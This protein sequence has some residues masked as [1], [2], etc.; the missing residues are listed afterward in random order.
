M[1]L[2][3]TEQLAA[4]RE[5]TLRL[6]AVRERSAAELRTRLRTRGFDPEVIDQTLEKMAASGLQSDERFAERFA[7]DIGAARGWS[8]RRTKSELLGRGLS[9]ELAEAAAAQDPEG[10]RDRAVEVARKQVRRM[11][12]LAADVRVRRLAGLLARRGYGSDICL[13]VALEVSGSEVDEGG[14]P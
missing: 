5:S 13:S 1:A 3:F 2:P 9:R 14:I 7:Q 6:L 10:D 8:S 4:A 12:G 11:A